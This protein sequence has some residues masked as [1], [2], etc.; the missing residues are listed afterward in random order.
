LGYG[1]APALSYAAP[2]L[3][4][5]AYSYA[6]PA[7][8]GPAYSYAT[9]ALAHAPTLSYAAPALAAPALAAP[10]LAAP[11][12]AHSAAVSTDY[13]ICHFTVITNAQSRAYAKLRQQRC[14]CNA[15]SCIDCIGTALHVATD[16]HFYMFRARRE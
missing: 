12:I 8:A 10:A 2:A 15:I 6:A 11:A 16:V 5:P 1:A 9:S 14:S 3:A 7:L 4:A 13:F